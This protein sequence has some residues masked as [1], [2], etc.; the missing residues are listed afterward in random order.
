MKQNRLVVFVL[1][2][3]ALTACANADI[4]NDAIPAGQKASDF[5]LPDQDGKMWTLAETL[6]E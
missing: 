4:R 6:K 1:A 2:L 5:T 3:V